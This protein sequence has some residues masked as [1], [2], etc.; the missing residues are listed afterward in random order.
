MEREEGRNVHEDSESEEGMRAK[1]E[2]VVIV[3]SELGRKDTLPNST[4]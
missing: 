3:E 4:M 2:V 1:V